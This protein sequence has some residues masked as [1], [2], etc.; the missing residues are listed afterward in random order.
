MKFCRESLITSTNSDPMSLGNM[1]RR[2]ISTVCCSIHVIWLCYPNP[3][4]SVTVD[5]DGDDD[6]WLAGNGLPDVKEDRAPWAGRKECSCEWRQ[7]S[8]H[9]DQWL[10]SVESSRQWNR[11]WGR[12]IR[13][14]SIFMV[15]F[16]YYWQSQ[17]CHLLPCQ[18]S[19]FSNLKL[20][21]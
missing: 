18:L 3:L 7:S 13:N 16:I 6:G 12:S 11:V 10:W 19:K 17:L 4:Q 14:I 5:S 20:W 8:S 21:A 2:E 1:N 15:M 9:E